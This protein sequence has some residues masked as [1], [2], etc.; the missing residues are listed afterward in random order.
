[1]LSKDVQAGN[2][3][4]LVKVSRCLV[5]YCFVTVFAMYITVLKNCV[6]RLVISVVVLMLLCFFRVGI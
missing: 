2:T 5:V 6:L 3:Q 1:V 4:P